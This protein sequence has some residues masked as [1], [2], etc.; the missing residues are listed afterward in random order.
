MPKLVSPYP[1]F[2]RLSTNPKNTL[3]V[4]PSAVPCFVSRILKLLEKISRNQSDVRYEELFSLCVHFFGAPRS[5][6]G[7]HA[8]FRMPWKGDPRV[9]IQSAR[10][11][12]KEYQVR[13]VLAAISRLNQESSSNGKE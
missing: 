8:V 1:E 12:A 10:G 6:R 13:Q 4:V 5:H 11:R 7:S 3:R 2:F 9:N